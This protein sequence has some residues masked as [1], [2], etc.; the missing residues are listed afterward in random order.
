MTAKEILAKVK[1]I[2]DA[3]VA[4]PAAPSVVP[5]PVV[6]VA[7]SAYK[8]KDGTEVTISMQGTELAVGDMVM[9]AGAPPPA[10]E[11]ELED[12]TKITVDAMGMVTLVT[13]AEPVTQPDFVAPP[14]GPSIEDRIAAIETKIS[15]LSTPAAPTGYATEDQYAEALKR[16]SKQDEVIKGLFELVEAMSKE[17]A[18]EPATL[19][20]RQKQQFDRNTAKEERLKK[21]S[22]GIKKVKTLN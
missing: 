7:A 8:L 11:L 17:P 9:I 13:P 19:T 4:T 5:T 10:G 6:P 3:P 20:G 2:F 21:I 16:I 1:A 22:D 15:M 12:G 18:A 14:T